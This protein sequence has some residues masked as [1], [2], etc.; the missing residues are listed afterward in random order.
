V[1]S[2]VGAQ[3][4]PL[5]EAQSGLWYAQ[6]VDPE[7]PLFNTGQY[8]E[9]NGPLDLPAFEAALAQAVRE[10][11][12]LAL[13]F[14][15][16]PGGPWQRVDPANRPALEIIDVSHAPDP[17]AAAQADIARDM[18]TPVD[19]AR[20]QLAAERLFILGAQ[21]F[22]WQQ[23]IH[24]LAIDGYGM[25]LLTR[26][27]VELYNTARSGTPAS[28]HAPGT[29]VAFAEDA[30]Y[31][32]A[33]R[34]VEDGDYWRALFADRPDVA[35][36]ATGTPASAHSFH[37]RAVEIDGEAFARLKSVGERT[38]IPWPDVVTA[39]SA[40]YVQR[41]TATEEVIVGV[42]FMARLGSAAARVPAMLMN[43]LP[44]RVSAP[45]DGALDDFLAEVARSLTRARRHGRYRSEQLRRDLK[46]I[47]GRHR[48]HGP[49]V[50][51]LPFDETPRFDGLESR[52]EVLSTGPVEDITFTFRLHGVDGLRLEVDANPT[53]YPPEAV[54]AHAVRLRHFIAAASGAGTLVEVPTATPDEAERH[55]FALNATDHPVPDT[56]LAGLI[57]RALAA[58]PDAPALRFDGASMDYATL[59]ARSRALAE[60]LVAGG[61]L[62]DGLIAVALPRSFEL[63]I[64]LVAIL[65]AG[66]AYLPLDLAQPDARLSRILA[67]A[68]P[69]LVL[70]RTEE[71]GRFAGKAE[72]LAP[73]DW[74]HAPL[75]LEL[76]TPEPDD[77]AYVIY[78]SGSTGE[79]KGVVIEHR[80]I[81]NRLEW[82]RA[83]YGFGS[84]DRIL[85]KTPATFDVS[86]WEFF[87]PFLAG[88]CLVIAPPEAHRDPAALARIIR[89]EAVTTAH[90]VP[91]MLAAF[92]AEPYA[93]GLALQRVFCSG[94][95]LPA[96]LRDRFHRTL[97]AEL[98]NLYGPTEAAVDVSY[99]PAGPDDRTTPVP[100]G[101]PVWNTRLYV[102]DGQG[103]PQPPGVPGHLF[104]GGVQLARGYLGRPDLTNERFL[105]DPFR[106]GERIYA[107][108]DLAL[109][110]PDGAVVF[111]GRS[112]HQI[113]IRGLRVEL[114]EIETA[115][116]SSGLVRQA[117]ILA[118][119]DR[120]TR[121][122]V[123]Y[124]VPE[125][126]AELAALRTHLAA[127][128][129]DYMV[130]AAFV[131]LAALPVTANG[132]LDRAALPAPDF[133]GT[134]SRAPQSPTEIALAG[135]FAQQLEL[136]API[137]AEDD[138]F[139]L[140]GDS[141]HAVALLLKVR[142]A[143]G[144]DPGLGALFAQP[145]VEGFA[146]LIEAEG[147]D[148][149][150]LGP[151]ITLQEGDPGL[152]PLFA[153]HPAGGLS[154][155]YGRLARSL[156]PRRTVYGVQAPALAPDIATPASLD[157]LAAD[158]VARIRRVRPHGPYH[159][160]GWSVGG[161]IAQAMAAKLRAAD[162]EVG[163]VALLDSYPC[164]VWRGEPDPGEAGALKAL[165]A[166]AGH[167]PDKLPA[168][169]LN[170]ASVLAFLRATNSPLGRL[171]EAA[172]DGVVRVV[173]G[174]NALVRGH[175]HARFDGTLTHFRAALDHQGR[176]LSPGLWAPYAARVEV[177]DVPSLHAH[178]TGQEATALIAPVLARALHAAEQKEE[179]RCAT[180]V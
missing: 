103:R 61:S 65:R 131:T 15:D 7:N 139:A 132:K 84:Q 88:G 108:G 51:V 172:L 87:L 54:E 170:R 169:A 5:T 120:S 142:E 78:T 6:R 167:D 74:P 151:L 3:A 36:L 157:A 133:A 92:L 12:A 91:S 89:E 148:D 113:K 30:A 94:E 71:A 155:C 107:T 46:L 127:R 173:A 63:V 73:E 164:D 79:P 37:R 154:W 44:L 99:W 174:N 114:G 50:N 31:R 28:A 149:A 97:S 162:A 62:K 168:L 147:E 83:H 163:V 21:R 26:R 160:L 16:E 141:L 59:D 25:I 66:A 69:R 119:E 138:F 47:G 82:M 20:G 1:V 24:H 125:P 18:A 115:V 143:F 57:E 166:I 98:H 175:F 67:S 41:H 116:M 128:L 77:A 22:V 43:V 118:R 129:P 86:V 110:R 95:E 177:I 39:L 19:P 27:I 42:P 122:I 104:L 105:P 140:G 176:D 2:D 179:E 58:T 60:K 4:H 11:D 134:G 100:I 85:Q 45:A 150:G 109:W 161:I 159:L 144:R 165:I 23:R 112:D 117:A 137:A 145:T 8:I 48:L 53:L 40:A 121:R 153:I 180:A 123:A 90:F 70:A 146:R 111:L 14:V 75:G 124:V 33:D 106:P 9:L 68:G 76:P 136:T 158:Y 80:A 56:T 96:D 64:A 13:R 81:V 38:D 93:Q 178:L 72:V 49:L 171:P 130:P 32:A 35:S 152:P 102:L 10:A 101:F 156:G 135:L 29:A 34:R 52:L 55:V 126:G 17:L